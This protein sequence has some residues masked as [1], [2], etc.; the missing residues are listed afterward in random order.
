MALGLICVLFFGMFQT[1]LAEE[2]EKEIK[3]LLNGKMIQ[4]DVSPTVIDDRT[5][6]PIRAV[7]EGLGIKV[8]WDDSTETVTVQGNL[9]KIAF[10]LDSK[11]ATVITYKD[12]T[13]T[14]GT[15]EQKTLDVPATLVD[16]RTVIPLRFVGE[17][18]G[19]TVVWN[20]KW[21]NEYDMIVLYNSNYTATAEIGI[22]YDESGTKLYE[23]GLKNGLPEGQGKLYY[24]GALD[25]DG[26]WA[27]G[28]EK[29]SGKEFY[30][31]NGQVLYEGEFKDSHWNGY[32][33][34]YYEDGKPMYEGNFVNDDYT[35]AG[36]S[37][38][39]NGTLQYDGEFVQGQMTG[40]GKYYSEAGILQYEGMLLNG[41]SNG[42]GKEYYENGNLHYEGDYINGIPNGYGKVYD[43]DGNLQY[44]GQIANGEYN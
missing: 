32:G 7:V 41:V 37:Y 12:K 15:K 8:Q 23:G 18:L 20:D 22:L 16:N 6:I 24:S 44:E 17:N 28:A 13:D 31:M 21:P 5:M 3:V 4:M 33:K 19:L 40:Y 35:G 30:L 9:K 11:D 39:S 2:S 38:Y 1:C 36:K 29:G 43:E 10:K 42:Q 27:N 26:T 25:Y 34:A 14:V